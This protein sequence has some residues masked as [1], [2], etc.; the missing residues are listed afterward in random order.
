M[1]ARAARKSFSHLFAKKIGNIDDCKAAIHPNFSQP[2]I[3][4]VLDRIAPI[5]VSINTGEL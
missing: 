3:Y 5:S 1:T 2:F 4:N